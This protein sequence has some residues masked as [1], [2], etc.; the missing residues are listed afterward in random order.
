MKIFVLA[1]NENWI[2]DRIAQEW[3]ENN[4][5]ITTPNIIEADIIWLLAGWCWN[6]IPPGMLQSKKVIVTVHHLVPEKMNQQ[7]IYDFLMRDQFV[8]CY[9]VPNRKTK[10]H[11][12]RLTDKKI[13]VISYWYDESKWYPED[14]I[15]ARQ[16]LLLP[17]NDYIVGSFQRDTEGSDLVTPKFE[18]GPDIFC[19]YV[20]SLDVNN[21]HVLLGGFRRQYVIK[22]LE[23]AGIKYSYFE[24]AP[25][26]KLRKMY[27]SCDLYVIS[28]R[29]EGG[30]QSALEASAM[31]VPIIS[32]NVGI[33]ENILTENCIGDLSFQN[34]IP[35][36]D[37]VQK[38]FE[39]CQ[40][41][42][43]KNHKTMYLD[44]FSEVSSC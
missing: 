37:D 34:Y 20:E 43:I 29:H 7:K 21:L 19:D 33:V 25:I 35:S 28:S 17:E 24:L 32:T 1:P 13:E 5:E 16:F 8:D 39:N 10:A 22:R 40:K 36:D 15:Q 41:Y 27:A 12:E 9:H 2:C 6:H 26:E 3:W 23:L 11:L 42:E 44:L 31:K 18:K 14:K 38:G 30:P 4:T